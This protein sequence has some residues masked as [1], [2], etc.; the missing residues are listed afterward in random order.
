MIKQTF[1]SWFGGG[2]ADGFLSAALLI[3]LAVYFLVPY[4]PWTFPVSLHTPLLL[5]GL[6]LSGARLLVQKSPVEELF[7]GPLPYFLAMLVFFLASSLLVHADRFS[8]SGFQSYLLSFF[9]FLFVL[10][11]ARCLDLGLFYSGLNAYLIAAGVL[12][13][14][15][16]TYAGPF[17]VSG[18]LG[19]YGFGYTTQGWGF[20]NSA[21]LSGGVMTWCFSVALARYSFSGVG[22]QSRARDIFALSAVGF[23][24]VGLFYTIS[25][26]AWAGSVLAAACVL[27]ALFLT[28]SPKKNFLK[29]LLSVAVFITVFCVFHS[30][31]VYKK[32]E[33]LMFFF[34]F[35][36]DPK[37]TV[38]HDTSVNTRALAWGL[39]LKE[40][41]KAP[42]WGIGLDQFP[43][44]YREAYPA[45]SK[46]AKG[47]MDLNQAINPHNSYLYYAVEVGV[48]PTL[49]LLLLIARV[50][51]AGLKEGRFS[52][53][54]PFLIGLIAVCL[55]TCTN[56]YLKERIF[57]I[58]LGL[59]AGL[60]FPERERKN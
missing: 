35:L 56:D 15:Q 10:W 45:L 39:A 16:V 22:G 23:G 33:K 31:E 38:E 40:I 30:P 2:R 49:F 51:L 42:V 26:A 41:K 24:A 28:K 19:H 7:S 47:N 8:M 57:W 20:V 52:E 46:S 34:R 48:L 50:L 27:A 5:L 58:V 29:A 3:Y 44:L 17:Y 25:L 14:L 54:C 37:I 36:F 18:F 1:N 60:A 12:I 11:A 6:G 9:S 21:T 53:A 43:A 13:L 59:T 55:W 32:R 4:K